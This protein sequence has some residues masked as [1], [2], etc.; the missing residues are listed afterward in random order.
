MAVI[1]KMPASIRC[2]MINMCYFEMQA[3]TEISSIGEFMVHLITFFPYY[4]A[5]NT[6][7]H[8]TA[9]GAREKEKKYMFLKKKYIPLL[10][11]LIYN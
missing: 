7:Y 9:V 3:V 10:S 5:T 1:V 2:G 11:Q 8:K 4:I 6:V